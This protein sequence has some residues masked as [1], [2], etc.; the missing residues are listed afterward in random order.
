MLEI[1]LDHHAKVNATPS[2]IDWHII[3][4]SLK[5]HSYPESYSHWDMN[6]DVALLMECCI[7]GS[8]TCLIDG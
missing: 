6:G 7:A 4:M 5:L 1:C 8:R 3:N 2:L